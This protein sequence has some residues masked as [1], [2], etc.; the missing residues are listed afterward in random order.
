[1]FPEL[2][3]QQWLGV[4]NTTT[5]DPI[6]H[7]LDHSDLLLVLLVE[8]HQELIFHNVARTFVY[9]IG[10]CEYEIMKDA[11]GWDDRTC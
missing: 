4:L 7:F 6:T 5:N 3:N 11:G 1:M 10:M 2:R 8:I 9:H